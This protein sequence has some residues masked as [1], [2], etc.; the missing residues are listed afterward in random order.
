MQY[1]KAGCYRNILFPGKC[2]CEDNTAGDNCERCARGYYG[3][4]LGGTG[5]DCKQC[6]CPGQGACMLIGDDDTIFCSE[7]PRGYGGK[8]FE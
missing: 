2:I 1:L 6:P 4:A 3:N 8:V 7:C 5:L